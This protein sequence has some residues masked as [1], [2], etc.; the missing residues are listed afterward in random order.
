MPRRRGIAN[1][2]VRTRRLRPRRRRRGRRAPI[3]RAPRRR[4]SRRR[5]R[6][7][8]FAADRLR[9]PPVPKSSTRAGRAPRR[10]RSRGS[11]WRN[12]TFCCAGRRG[13]GKR[14]SR[15]RSP[16]SWTCRSSWRTRRRSRRLATWARTWSLCCISFCRRRISTWTPR[17]AASCTWTRSISS[18]G[19]P[20]TSASRATSPARGC[21][22]LSSRWSR[23][24]SS[25]SRRRAGGKIREAS[26]SRST[27]RTYSSYAAARSPAWRR[28][29]RDDW[30]KAE[31]TT[32]GE[33]ARGTSPGPG[34]GPDPSRTTRR[35]TMLRTSPRDRRRPTRRTRASARRRTRPARVVASTPTAS[36][37]R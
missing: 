13:A 1:R 3:A 21:S 6:R 23:E 20:K 29:S 5:N 35:R 11:D 36:R 9:T 26:S 37:P 4:N 33:H 30:I 16:I 17:S 2:G 27:P 8:V 15:E 31:P 10:R 24:P 14:C 34:P 32:G 22:R 25:T 18:R 28:S 7:G 19:N 12:P